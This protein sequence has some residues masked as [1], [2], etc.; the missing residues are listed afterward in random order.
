MKAEKRHGYVVC[1]GM[2]SS[3]RQESFLKNFA[4]CRQRGTFSLNL[5]STIAFRRVFCVSI[6]WILTRNSETLQP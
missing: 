3:L 2:E 5:E 6:P 4:L 1:R